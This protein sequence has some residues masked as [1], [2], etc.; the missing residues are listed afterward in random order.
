MENYILGLKDGFVMLKMATKP[1]K[2]L[3][4]DKVGIIEA[5]TLLKTGSN[6]E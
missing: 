4:M 3:I 6:T 5:K 1:L 2:Y